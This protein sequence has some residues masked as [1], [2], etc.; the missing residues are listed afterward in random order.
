MAKG[1]A[2]LERK[3]QALGVRVEAG[4]TP[5]QLLAKLEQARPDL[6]IKIA[7]L[8]RYLDE[9]LYQNQRQQEPKFRALVQD[10][11]KSL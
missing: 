10:L 11:T 2:S 1:V 5:Q 6:A 8:Y 9:Y 4:T 7:V 3:A